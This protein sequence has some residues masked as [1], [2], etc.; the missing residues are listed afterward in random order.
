[1]VVMVIAKG[2]VFPCG[3][4]HDQS[5]ALAVFWHMRDAAFASGF[6]VREGAS[7][8]D[9]LAVDAGL[10]LFLST[11]VAWSNQR[12]RRR[13]HLPA[14]TCTAG[15]VQARHDCAREFHVMLVAVLVGD[16]V[17]DGAHA[18]AF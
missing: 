12:Q 4:I 13:P 1:M 18:D 11:A 8:V 9:L 7:Q 2:G 14:Q 15:A 5:V 17:I 6:R 3:E 16:T 10:S